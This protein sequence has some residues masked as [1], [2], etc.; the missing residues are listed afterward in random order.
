[1]RDISKNVKCQRHGSFYPGSFFFIGLIAEKIKTVGKRSWGYTFLKI[2]LEFKILEKR[3]YQS[4]SK[5]I[6]AKLWHPSWKFHG[7]RK[8]T[9][10]MEVP[11]VCTW[12]FLLTPQTTANSTSFLQFNWLLTL[13]ISS[14]L[15]SVAL[16]ILCPPNSP[17]PI[18]FLAGTGIAGTTT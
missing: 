1:M 10:A 11:Y 14:A 4:T 3:S 2:F 15:S 17:C 9:K 7:W 6:S 13:G 5:R 12:V 8:P 16:K 18:W